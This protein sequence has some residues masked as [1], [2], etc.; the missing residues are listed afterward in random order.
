V[1]RSGGST[2]YDRG[3]HLVKDL[4]CFLVGSLT[5]M[6]NDQ[7][8]PEVPIP[9]VNGKKIMQAWREAFEQ[10]TAF[11]KLTC[12]KWTSNH[13]RVEIGEPSLP[14]IFKLPLDSGAG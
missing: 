14:S 10:V 9:H 5:W 6:T 4:A 2:Y 7:A 8:P 1:R 13:T 12:A 11:S 3:V